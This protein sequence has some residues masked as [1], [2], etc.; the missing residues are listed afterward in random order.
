MEFPFDTVYRY[1]VAPLI[2]KGMPDE[3]LEPTLMLVHASSGAVNAAE[4][5]P[6]GRLIE[7]PD[8]RSVLAWIE[9]MRTTLPADSCFVLIAETF[10]RSMAARPG[11]TIDQAR[12]RGPSSLAN[13]PEAVEM[14]VIQIYRPNAT[15]VGMLPI[16]P[17][18]KL[19]YAPL[20]DHKVVGVKGDGRESPGGPSTTI[21]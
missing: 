16:R 3:V 2:E 20:R 8:T 13:D 17:G 9:V 14:V 1:L 21:H 15:R 6:M 10:M 11:E 5:L 19:E 7:R 18:R 12:Q 4:V